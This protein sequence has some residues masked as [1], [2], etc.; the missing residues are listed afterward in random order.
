MLKVLLSALS[1][2][3]ALAPNGLLAQTPVYRLL[4][5]APDPSSQGAA[6]ETVFETAPGTFYFLSGM[7]GQTFGPSI[8]SLTGAGSAKLIYSFPPQTLS[9]ALVQAADGRLYGAVFDSSR[10]G[11]YYSVSTA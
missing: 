9:D 10:Q 2:A 8:F 1:L 4:Y 11:L 3:F 6:P 7:Q 5:S